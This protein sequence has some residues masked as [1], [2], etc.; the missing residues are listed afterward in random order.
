[1][2]EAEYI[3]M[4]TALCNVI[5]VMELIK[6]MR[7]HTLTSSGKLEI[8]RLPSLHPRTKHINVCNHHFRENVRRSLIT[9]AARTR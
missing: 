3:A 8:A 4:S 9:L 5:T 7:E 2:T 6:E 1:M